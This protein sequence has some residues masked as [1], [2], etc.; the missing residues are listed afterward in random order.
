MVIGVGGAGKSTFARALSARTSLPVIHLDVHYWRPGWVAPQVDE[1]REQ[2]GTLLASDD[3]IV[4]GNDLSTVDLR[5]ERAGTVVFL[6]TPRWLCATRALMRG[7]RRRPARFQLP[8]GCDEPAWQRL[9][10]EWRLA[11]RIWR[12]HSSERE[13]TLGVLSTEGSPRL[14]RAPF[15]TRRPQLPRGNSALVVRTAHARRSLISRA[16]LIG[17]SQTDVVS[18]VPTSREVRAALTV[19][20]GDGWS[21]IQNAAGGAEPAH[22]FEIV[23]AC[24]SAV[25]DDDDLLRFVGDDLLWPPSTPTGSTIAYSKPRR[26]LERCARRSPRLTFQRLRS[27]SCVT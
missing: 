15:E 25:A 6:D 22:A 26:H 4:D 20:T 12:S 3:W 18:R 24:L 2:Q 19:G 27:T 21:A 9:R 14:A 17:R 23:V 5:L 8:V 1:W 13:Q 16:R 7:I 11:W 10:E